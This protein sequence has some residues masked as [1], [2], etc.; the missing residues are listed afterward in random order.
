MDIMILTFVALMVI[1]GAMSIGVLM[2]RKPI[3][4]SCGG[5]SALGMETACDICGGDKAR[6]EKEQKRQKGAD[7]AQPVDD[8]LAYEVKART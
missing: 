7:A 3:A 2:G 1:I 5:M 6:C 4:G 8:E